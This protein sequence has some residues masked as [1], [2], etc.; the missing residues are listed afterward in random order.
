MS[1]TQSH[2]WIPIFLALEQFETFV[3]P[4]LHIGSRG[5]QPKLTLHVIF[6]YIL[7]FLHTGCQWKELPIEK[8]KFGRPE[9]HYLSSLPTL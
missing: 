2:K 9:I 8:D 7:E 4:H 1:Q 6:N 3:V 5:P